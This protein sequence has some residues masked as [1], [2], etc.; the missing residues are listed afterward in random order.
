MTSQHTSPILSN[1]HV[2]VMIEQFLYPIVLVAGASDSTD[3]VC[4]QRLK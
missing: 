1:F 3:A 2:R 4:R